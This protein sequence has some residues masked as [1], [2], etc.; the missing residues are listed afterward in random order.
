MYN[1]YKTTEDRMG[2]DWTA[3]FIIVGIGVVTALIIGVEINGVDGFIQ[4]FSGETPCA[5]DLA[6]YQSKEYGLCVAN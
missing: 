4:S 3:L 6:D 5:V 2:N 1:D